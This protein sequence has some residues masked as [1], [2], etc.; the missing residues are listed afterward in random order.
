MMR[1]LAFT[2]IHGNS[3]Q[4]HRIRD[5]ITSA[6]LII[7]T[8]DITNFGR[9]R[10]LQQILQNIEISEDDIFAIHGNCD[11]PDVLQE[12]QSNGLSIH[13]TVRERGGFVFMGSGGSLPCP[14]N[15][16]SEYSETELSELLE[17]SYNQV[18]D[19]PD[20]ILVSHQPPVNTLNDIVHGGTHVGS[21]AVRRFIEKYQ[22]LVCLTGHIHEGIGID[23]IGRTQIVNAGPFRNGYYTSLI[24]NNS[25]LKIE[26]KHV[27]AGL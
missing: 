15:T 21:A 17:K 3:E 26:L 14:G 4:F 1:V 24:L 18:G 23:K 6:D 12:L 7:L 25:E 22:P 13:G 2:D 27:G 5:E 8:G 11:F 16:P 10:E 20:F 19:N 9:G